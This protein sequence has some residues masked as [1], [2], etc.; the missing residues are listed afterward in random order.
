MTIAT[1]FL[2]LFMVITYILP[3]F[4]AYSRGH[5]NF[6]PLLLV[7]IVLGWTFLF[8]FVCLVWALWRKD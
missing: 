5:K 3:S 1:I 4:I 7:N 6:L 2:M 8:W